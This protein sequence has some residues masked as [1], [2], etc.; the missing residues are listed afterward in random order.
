MRCII[1]FSKDKK[2]IHTTLYKNMTFNIL[3]KYQALK[4]KITIFDFLSK[5]KS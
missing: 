2:F 5:I 4:K 3:I 1:Q